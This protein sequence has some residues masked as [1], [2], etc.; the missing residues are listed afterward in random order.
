MDGKKKG[1]FFQF[2]ENFTLIKGSK[3]LLDSEN[4]VLLSLLL[5]EI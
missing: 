4:F 2:P 5:H 3:D 1:P